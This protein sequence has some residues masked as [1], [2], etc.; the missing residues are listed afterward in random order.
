MDNNPINLD[1]LMSKQEEVQETAQSDVQD[2]NETAHEEVQD[3]VQIDNDNT[4][5]QNDEQIDDLTEDEIADSDKIVEEEET[6]VSE[7][8]VQ[9]E[10]VETQ[11]QESPEI[12]NQSYKDEYIKKVVDY[13]EKFGTLEPFLEATQV[14]YDRIDDVDLLRKHFDKENIDLPLKTRDRLFKR[15]LEKYNLDSYE[16]DDKEIGQDLLKRDANKLRK[17]YKQEQQEFLNN[18]TPSEEE[19]QMSEQQLKELQIKQRRDVEGNINKV[20]KDNFIKLEANGEALNYQLADKK[21]VIDYAIDSSSFISSFINDNG[22]DWDKWTKVVAFA[23]N[24]TQFID[25]LIKHGKSLGRKSMESELKNSTIDK[26]SKDVQSTIDISHPTEN[27][28]AF[29]D[30][31]RKFRK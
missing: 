27:P 3:D 2:S 12:A 4:S 10:I 16:D 21:K 25:E 24:P 26:V 9:E 31:L 28:D 19:K 22:V 18:I 15:E 29:L 6:I 11:E 13:Y 14:D 30:E 17:M 20:V 1:E 23:E 5:V 8:P 7:Q